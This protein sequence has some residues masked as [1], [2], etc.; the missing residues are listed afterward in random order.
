MM[1]KLWKTFVGEKKSVSFLMFDCSSSVAFE[2][3]DG[4][5]TGVLFRCYD[6]FVGVRRMMI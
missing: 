4:V 3:W 5:F 6:A 2:F 1:M